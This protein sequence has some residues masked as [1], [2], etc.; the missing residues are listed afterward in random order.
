M[1]VELAAPRWATITIQLDASTRNIHLRPLHLQ[2]PHASVT[3][4]PSLHNSACL[5]ACRYH[6][7]L[8]A[9][10]AAG[11]VPNATLHHFTHPDWWEEMGAFEKGKNIS[12][13]VD[14]CVL[15]A[16]EFGQ[17]IRLWATFNEPT[18]YLVCGYLI[19]AHPPGK[20]MSFSLMGRVR[21]AAADQTPKHLLVCCSKYA[22]IL[23]HSGK[24]VP[25][26]AVGAAASWVAS[27]YLA[28]SSK[29][30]SMHL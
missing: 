16:R 19:G 8:D 29:A 15:C 1:Q 22:C 24:P 21:R 14:F 4:S 18:C 26:L 11:M 12:A 28:R 2:A 13:F 30:Q 7:I 5:C 20:L 25:A 3:H 6:K 10:E 9:I 27:N 17:R 23:W